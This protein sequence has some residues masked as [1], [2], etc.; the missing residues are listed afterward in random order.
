MLQAWRRAS[1]QAVVAEDVGAVEQEA[2]A[3][4]LRQAGVLDGDLQE[5]LRTWHQS[6]QV[7][8]LRA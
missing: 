8:Q 3:A 6:H 5:V 4:P 7:R 2:V 1:Q